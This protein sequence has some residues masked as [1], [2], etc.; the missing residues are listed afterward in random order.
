MVIHSRVYRTSIYWVDSVIAFGNIQILKEM[1]K[2]LNVLWSALKL[3]WCM[4][5]ILK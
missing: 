1:H 3:A 4:Q 5:S 2:A